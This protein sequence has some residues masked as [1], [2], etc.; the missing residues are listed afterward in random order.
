MLAAGVPA[1]VVGELTPGAKVWVDN[2]PAVYRAL[3]KR[4]AASVRPVP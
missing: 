2:N 1:R 3:A 4:H